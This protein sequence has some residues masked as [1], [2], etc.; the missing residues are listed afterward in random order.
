MSIRFAETKGGTN[1]RIVEEMNYFQGIKGRTIPERQKKTA[2]GWQEE[3][4][5]EHA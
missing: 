1:A 2:G 4:E 3:D 5:M